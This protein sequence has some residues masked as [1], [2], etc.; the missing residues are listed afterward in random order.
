LGFSFVA[1]LSFAFGPLPAVPEQVMA[2]AEKAQKK[3]VLTP[4]RVDGKNVCVC[5]SVFLIFDWL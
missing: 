5:K 4:H 1:S 2:N 3:L